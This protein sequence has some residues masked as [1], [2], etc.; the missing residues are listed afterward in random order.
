MIRKALILLALLILAL[1]GCSNK[2]A[3]IDSKNQ[4]A[5]Y[6]FIDS[7]D[8]LVIL[9]KKPERVVSLVGSYAETWMLAGGEI[10]GATDDVVKEN[11]FEVSDEIS[12]VGTVKDPSVE[13]ILSLSP[14]FVI[15]SPDIE[16]QLKM[17]E[18]L[19]DA[20]IAHAYFKVEYFEDYLNMLY[21]CTDITEKK[22]LYEEN[23]LKVKEEIDDI[24][25]KVEDK[26]Q[27]KPAV[28]FVRAFSSGA[29]AKK[30][31]NLTCKMLED[32]GT[33]NIANKHPSLLEELSMEE[34]I[35]E[36]PDYIFVTTM[37]N[38][39]KALEALKNGIE[40]NPAWNNLTA[41]KNDR[42]IILPK[43][44][45]HYKPNAKWGESYRYLAEIIYPEI[46]N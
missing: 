18:I 16:N 10:I 27:E 25:S 13:E 23:G 17:S 33:V 28:L 26:A 24:L 32:L 46:F 11:R 2:S 1:T 31:D 5:Y 8:N 43:E 4:E 38:T 21:I 3:N 9:E 35:E 36:D 22:D 29:K 19:N 41:V 39:E 30:D 7:L 20:N 45:F 42:Y 15:L 44:L 6:T 12:I 34:I 40:K 14:D 37:G